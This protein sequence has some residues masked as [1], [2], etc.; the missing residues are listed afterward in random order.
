[1]MSCFPQTESLNRHSTLVHGL[2]QAAD[3]ALSVHG[4]SQAAVCNEP[5]D[6]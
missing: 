6:L 5:L 3:T 4:L 2:S 1:M